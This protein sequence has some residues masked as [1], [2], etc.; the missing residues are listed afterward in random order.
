MHARTHTHTHMHARTHTHM[1]TYTHA[2]THTHTQTQ[3]K[4]THSEGSD[5]GRGRQGKML[6]FGTNVDLSDEDI[7]GTQLTEL[8]KLPKFLQVRCTT[9]PTLP[10]VL[11][12]ISV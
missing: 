4:S 1:H 8:E 12:V 11:C 3:D 2:H 10:S 6:R 9:S 5:D 7:W